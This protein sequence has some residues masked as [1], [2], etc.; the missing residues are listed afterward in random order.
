[1]RHLFIV[2]P[3]AGKGKTGHHIPTI[4]K[5]CKER[6]LD[7]IIEVTK[8]PGDAAEIAKRYTKEEELRVYSVGGDG[9]LNEVVNGMAE[10]SSSLAVI[11]SGSGNDFIRNF[12]SSHNIEE[13]LKRSIEGSAA[14]LD[15]GKLNGKYFINISS[16]GLDAEIVYKAI[17]LKKSPF[18]PS[19]FAYLLSI[20]T[21]V[22]GY[23]GK[24][25]RVIM[26]NVEI[27][28]DT[29]LVAVA[30]GRY[31]GGGMRVA[32]QA[33]LSD[34]YFD[35]CHIKKVSPFKVIRLFPRLIKGTHGT[36]KEVNFY[37][38]KKVRIL[39]SEEITV[40]IDG[41]LLRMKEAGFEVVTQAINF[42]AIK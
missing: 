26:D 12:S 19:R 39:C 41:E 27:S 3:Q 32:P 22:F 28:G 9:T 25:L 30:N 38:T 2:N 37:K 16:V 11:P 31:Y 18:I 7:Y 36:I 35:I 15:L 6:S 42:V 4:E 29:L 1:M 24:N 14:P 20:F 8:G 10:S 40:N 17:K 13:I 21:T 23:K 33:E 34:G 5:L